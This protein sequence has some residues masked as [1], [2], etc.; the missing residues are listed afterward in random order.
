MDHLGP[1]G[2]CVVPWSCSFPPRVPCSKFLYESRTHGVGGVG[3]GPRLFVDTWRCHWIFMTVFYLRISGVSQCTVKSSRPRCLLKPSV[4]NSS[5]RIKK[6][7]TCTPGPPDPT[8]RPCTTS[9]PCGP[10][11][12]PLTCSERFRTVDRGRKTGG[13]GWGLSLPWVTIETSL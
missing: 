9:S 2:A 3:S 8:P 7:E 1:V 11:T 6:L 10:R 12:G 4:Y 13:W 5:W